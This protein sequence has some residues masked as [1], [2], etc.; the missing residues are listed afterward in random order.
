MHHQ[1]GKCVRQYRGHL[2]A[3]YC[4]AGD[5][6][7]WDGERAFVVAGSEDGAICIWDLQSAQLVAKA[8]S[9]PKEGEAEEERAVLAIAVNPQSGEIVSSSL[10]LPFALDFWR[11]MSPKKESEEEQKGENKREL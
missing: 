11:I 7:Q 8:D 6:F 1:L 9:P 5:L 2:N 3:K 4:C 10:S